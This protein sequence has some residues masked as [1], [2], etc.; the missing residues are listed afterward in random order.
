[1]VKALAS[2]AVGAGVLTLIHESAR[3]SVP[4]APR[5]DV[6]GMRAIDRVM[7]WMNVAL[8]NRPGLRRAAFAGDL[9]G[10]T[11]YYSAVVGRT[12]RDTWRRGLMLGAV[13]G[14]GALALPERI[15]LGT[16]PDSASRSNQLMTIAWYVIGGLAAAAAAN[17]F[18]NRRTN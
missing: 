9:V 7:A 11:L 10:N 16:P 13:A 12:P 3:R 14:V 18:R 5:M 17:A 2:G 15:G 8:L 4:R 6:V 1:M